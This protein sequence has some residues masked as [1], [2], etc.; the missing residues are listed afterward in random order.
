MS[1]VI[2]T[3][4]LEGIDWAEMKSTLSRDNFDNGR[5]PEQLKVSFYNSYAACIACYAGKIIGTARVLSDGVCNAYLVDVWTLTEFRRRGIASAM[6]QK[7]M[8]LLSGQHIYLQ[9]DDAL[10]FYAKLGFVEQPFG[11]GKVIGKWLINTGNESA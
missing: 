9:T 11:M 5:T 8:S 7:I 10:E 1:E 4:N 2:Y 6:I 3:T